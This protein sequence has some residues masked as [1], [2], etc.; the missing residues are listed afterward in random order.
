MCQIYLHY[1]SANPLALSL[2]ELRGSNQLIFCS[3][4]EHYQRQ[5]LEQWQAFSYNTFQ[6]LQKYHAQNL[7]PIC[8]PV[9]VLHSWSSRT[10][11]HISFHD[12]WFSYS[13]CTGCATVCDIGS[14]LGPPQIVCSTGKLWP[15]WHRM[16]YQCPV[17]F[18]PMFSQSP[19]FLQQP[20]LGF[21][22]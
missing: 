3:L 19:S 13:L 21:H 10:Q 14:R 1:P 15:T 17:Q 7:L 2:L 22:V 18:H 9:G 16:P 5:L 6:V 12:P 11:L 4:M 8:A 20:G